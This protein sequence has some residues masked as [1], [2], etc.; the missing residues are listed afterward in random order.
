MIVVSDA[1]PLMA[2]AKTGG[3]EALFLLSPSVLTPSAVYEEIVTAGLRLGASD[4]LLLQKLYASGTLVVEKPVASSLPLRVFLGQGEEESILLAIARNATWLLVDDLDARRAAAS[5]FEA[6]GG[7]TRVKG[8]L[9]IVLSA[10][11]EGGM[12]TQKGIE[13]VSALMQRPDIWISSR[14]CERVLSELKRG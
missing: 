14:L 2:L 10:C 7:K 8:T 3:L 11:Q 5:C 4:A 6:T 12:S 9:G 1:G 13:I